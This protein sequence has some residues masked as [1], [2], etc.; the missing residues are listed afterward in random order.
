MHN[1]ELFIQRA[2]DLAFLGLGSVSPNP[3]VGCV[4]VHH[5]KVIGEG[6][7]MKY[8][9]AHAEVNAINSVADKS[10]LPEST[11]YVSL[12]PCAH[13]GKTPP[14][15]DLLVR[16]RV[17][18]V[19]ISNMD[20]NP[21]VGGKGIKKLEEAGIEV[22]T[23]VLEREG[24]EINKRFFTGLKKKRPYIILKWAETED[25]FVARK[26]YDSKW[27]SN[28]TSRKL[29][30]KWRAEEDSIMVGTNTAYYDNPGLNVRDWSGRNPVRVVIDRNLRLPKNL[31][32][33]DGS[34][35]TICYNL[36]SGQ[37]SK[38]LQYVKLSETNFLEALFLNL[39]EH[40]LRSIIVE[41]GAQLLNLLIEKDMWD[42]ARVFISQTKFKEGIKAP[43]ISGLVAEEM[44]DTD[45]LLIYKN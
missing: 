9:D 19:V 21:L 32:I 14:C 27:I 42:E 8:G 4:I 2:F 6:W 10:L 3:L 41:G 30:H 13:F 5:N 43:A 15:S 26:N 33:F 31:K 12:E 22:V 18:R 1:D 36:L 11:V 37:A 28:E 39:Y 40:G 38:R 29:V 20:T 44:I 34:Q 23:G 7:H 17:K 24:L 16:H 25:G 35:P 45:K